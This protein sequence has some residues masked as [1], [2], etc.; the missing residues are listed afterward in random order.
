MEEIGTVN[1]PLVTVSNLW[2]QLSDTQVSMVFKGAF[3]E[4][5]ILPN[6]HIV[7]LACKLYWQSLWDDP[8]EI[9]LTGYDELWSVYTVSRRVRA[10]G[11]ESGIAWELDHLTPDELQT[12]PMAKLDL[13]ACSSYFYLQMVRST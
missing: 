3:S 8:V 1:E 2:H 7:D 5:S 12:L 9:S 4:A 11:V 6:R 10:I 13:A